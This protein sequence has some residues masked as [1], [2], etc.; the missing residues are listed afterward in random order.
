[1]LKR[2]INLCAAAAVFDDLAY[3]SLSQQK[4]SSW[5]LHVLCFCH[6][7]HSR[8]RGRCR[9]TEFRVLAL[10]EADEIGRWISGT[11]TAARVILTYV[12]RER[13]RESC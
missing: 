6:S 13:E 3:Y 4:C 9:L 10:H 1:M 7:L 5:W 8:S 11:T 2:L 12:E